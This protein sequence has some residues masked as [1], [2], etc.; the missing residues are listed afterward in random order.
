MMQQQHKKLLEVSEESKNQVAQARARQ[1]M[2]NCRDGS[3]SKA[4]E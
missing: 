4:G 2:P 1:P 3:L